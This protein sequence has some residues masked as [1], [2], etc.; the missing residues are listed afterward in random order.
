MEPEN[1]PEEQGESG[2]Q[3]VEGHC[4]Y[5]DLEALAELAAEARV[6]VDSEAMAFAG[7]KDVYTQMRDAGREIVG[8]QGAYRR[9]HRLGGRSW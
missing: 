1:T 6:Y 4:P 7:H 5:L 3:A 9:G 8:D 2:R